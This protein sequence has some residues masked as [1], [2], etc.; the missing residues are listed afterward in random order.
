[1]TAGILAANPMRLLSPRELA[2][3][4]GVSESSLK[5]WVDAGKIQASRTDG[6]HRKILLSEAV[7]FIRETGAPIARPEL[8]DLPEVA[9]AQQRGLG[10]TVRL[11]DH[12]LEGDVV[13]ARG[14]LMSRYLAGASIAELCD[15]PIK[16]A[17]YRLGELWRHD[18]GGI[19]VE[20]R[21]TDVCLQALAQLRALHD[22]PEE[23]PT[24]LGGAPDGDPYLLPSFMA[25]TVTAAAGMRAVNLGPDTPLVA[26]DA[27]V[28]HHAPRLV[29][30]SISSPLSP[31]RV[32]GLID[33]IEALPGSVLPIV[34]GQQSSPF[35]GAHAH[36]SFRHVHSM[37]EV[38]AIAREV[39]DAAAP[40]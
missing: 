22:P 32:R 3:A 12:L 38:E 34:G 18:E 2:E 23:A 33:W 40:A 26:F 14:W 28:Q 11:L 31:A 25:A 19:F 30:V 16:D 15:G 5:R 39:L 24:A 10:G 6:G 29:W 35:A 7:R 20:H 21:G 17:M 8:L 13:G 27:A 36:A 4:L 9:V 1:M 37:A